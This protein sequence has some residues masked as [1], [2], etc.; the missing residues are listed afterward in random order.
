ALSGS[1][2]S[3]IALWLFWFVLG[4]V[5]VLALVAATWELRTQSA[6]AVILLV[7]LQV[8]VILVRS[9][10]RVAAWGSYVAFLEPRAGRALSE[11]ARVRVLSASAA[12]TPTTATAGL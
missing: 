1:W 11:I 3:A 8:A 6:F 9:A 4:G 2:G 7:L 12:P 5:L 10:I